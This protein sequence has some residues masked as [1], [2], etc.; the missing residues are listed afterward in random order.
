MSNNTKYHVDADLRG[1]NA[2]TTR[3]LVTLSWSG[4]RPRMSDAHVSTNAMND[5]R[6]TITDAEANAIRA[7]VLEQT[8]MAIPDTGVIR[9]ITRS[10]DKS[11]IT[12][13]S[14]YYNRHD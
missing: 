6:V 13:D 5:G 14:T 3:R 7:A 4:R 9:F 10:W 1:H 2:A 11:V 8:G 12:I